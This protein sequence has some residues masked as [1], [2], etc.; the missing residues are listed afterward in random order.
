MTTLRSYWHLFNTIAFNAYPVKSIINA[1]KTGKKAPFWLC[2][3]G[4]CILCW[5]CPPY[6]FH[7]QYVCMLMKFK[8]LTIWDQLFMT[9]VYVRYVI[10]VVIRCLY[11]VTYLAAI[12]HCKLVLQ[13]FQCLRTM[14]IVHCTD[15]VT[16]WHDW[17]LITEVR[18]Y[19]YL[20]IFI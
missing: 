9:N 13:S 16:P 7:K 4:K 5:I 14:Y 12:K 3:R 1:E 8:P 10:K 17:W 2:F 11:I 15:V 6:F 18:K 19:I 20:C